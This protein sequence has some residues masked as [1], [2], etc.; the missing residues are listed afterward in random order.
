MRPSDKL[1]LAVPQAVSAVVQHHRP[2][3]RSSV[4][5]SRI[6]SDVLASYD[7]ETRPLCVSVS[8][9][10]RQAWALQERG[11]PLER[12]PREAY[13]ASGKWSGHLVLLAGDRLI[14][15]SLDGLSRPEHGID[16]EASTF[17]LP[18]GWGKNGDQLGV[19][20][21]PHGA[22]VRYLVD[23]PDPDLWR[24]APDW[25]DSDLARICRDTAVKVLG[26]WGF[27]KSP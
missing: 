6:A 9:F 19:E 22:Y 11:V 16:L 17:G 25:Q 8:A 21:P 13:S 10:N 23:D 20:I 24:T 14:D 3:P 2:Q 15:A 18:A 7:V 1:L 5:G 4:L 26:D 27:A 12:W